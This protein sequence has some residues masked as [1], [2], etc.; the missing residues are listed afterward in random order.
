MRSFKL[1][2]LPDAG[3]PELLGLDDRTMMYEGGQGQGLP[4][5]WLTFHWQAQGAANRAP[6]GFACCYHDGSPVARGRDQIP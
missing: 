6:A 1:L 5:G 4:R 2:L 3:P